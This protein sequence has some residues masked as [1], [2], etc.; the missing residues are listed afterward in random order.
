MNDRP[1]SPRHAKGTN[2]VELIKVL[3]IHQRQRPIDG[4]SP[5]AQELLDTRIL[6]S[7]W[8]PHEP[9]MELLRVLFEQLL[10]R[11]TDKALQ[12]GITG[13]ISS[14]K[15]PYKAYIRT[16]DPAASVLAMRHIWRTFFDFGDLK[17][18]LD[19]D[20]SVRFIL[21]G[22]RDVSPVHAAMITA[23]TVG[24]AR[25]AG[26]EKAKVEIV[27][28]PWDGAERLVYRTTF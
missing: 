5:E 18:S 25:L 15:G 8:Y 26:S 1:N 19:E 22:Y 3:K 10:G 23:W 9:F 4:L 6:L 12:I 21:T 16:G 28:A 27:E 20:G 13:S 11:S 14:L 17:A 24:A 2:L 7:D